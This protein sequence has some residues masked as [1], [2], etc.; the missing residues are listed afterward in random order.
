MTKK[1]NLAWKILGIIFGIII[2]V[3]IGFG[4]YLKAFLP[5][6]PLEDITVNVT[7]ERI[8]HGAY[9]ANH[10]MVC[11]DCHSVRDWQKFSGPVKPGTEG[12]G[13]EK[14]TKE[15]GFPG[16][17]YAP[18]I[19][20]FNLKGWSDGEI[21]R[22][23]TA[24]VNKQGKAL[25]PIMPYSGYGTLDREDIYDVI[26]YLR[27]LPSVENT[28]PPSESGFPMNFIINM[29]PKPGIP[30]A[31]PGTDD[32]LRYG[33]YTTR[34]GGCIDCH[35]RMEGGKHVPG[36]EFA[37]GQEFPLGRII[38]TSANITPDKGT[39]IGNWTEESFIA[40]FKVYDPAGFAPPDIPEGAFNTLMPWTMYAGMD[41]LDLKA[42]Y[43]YLMT[44]KPVENKVVLFRQK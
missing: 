23:I 19:T 44:V 29:I 37:G 28:M 2:L 10:V 40:R 11:M 26:A 18:N 21:Y 38:I 7:P 3:I 39:G 14:F 17:Y 34:A 6:I 22:A 31:R 16:N 1:K 15:M 36:V 8:D 32:L 24:G 42:I 41:T 33:E 5:A 4:I 9:L 30:A 35:T 12:R 27:E 20:P 25:F 13:G 43:A